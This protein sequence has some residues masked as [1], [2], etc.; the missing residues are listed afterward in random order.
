MNPPLSEA[1][2]AYIADHPLQRVPVDDIVR[3]AIA[4]EPALIGDPNTRHRIAKALTFMAESGSIHLPSPTS[5]S[6]WDERTQPP[7]PRWVRKHTP[8][9][10]R[11]RPVERVWPKQLERAAAIATRPDEFD[12]LGRIARWQRDNPNP[13][14]APIEERSL[15]I[16]DDEKALATHT[17][18]RLF[19]SGALSLDLLACY[20]TPILFPS[21]YVPGTGAPRLL[22]AENNATFH[23]LLQT[24]RTLD[25]TTRPSLHIGWGSGNQFPVSITAMALL[26]PLPE[27]VYYVGDLDVAGLRIAASAAAAAE[28]HN[29]PLLR[30]AGVLYRWLFANCTA[31]PDKSNRGSIDTSALTGWLPHDLRAPAAD[32]IAARRRI[33]QE[34]I[35]LKE[36]ADNPGLLLQ[37]VQAL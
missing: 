4:A 16:L 28:Q 32:L 31:G 8:L 10:E 22:V 29:L 35:G 24:A 14:A 9:A 26:D 33:P 18:K 37:A 27:A 25:P 7:L 12:L 15:E 36:L 1:M 13:L 11:S 17:T 34:R 30:P 19:T 23:S 21:Q 20:P 6:S 2:A 3:H 5:R